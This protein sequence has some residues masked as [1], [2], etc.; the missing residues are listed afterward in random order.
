[1]KRSTRLPPQLILVVIVAW[2]RSLPSRSFQNEISNLR[3]KNQS[4]AVEVARTFG[5]AVGVFEER[6]IELEGNILQ[7][8]KLLRSR[9]GQGGEK[10]GQGGGGGVGGGAGGGEERIKGLESKVDRIL[11]IIGGGRNV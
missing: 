7:E 6:I 2:L 1:M 8:L 3:D 11:S 5:D 10:K 9:Q 4:R